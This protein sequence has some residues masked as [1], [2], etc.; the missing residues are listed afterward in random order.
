MN[1]NFP[2][3]PCR[4]PFF[5]AS[6]VDERLLFIVT[7][8]KNQMT[9]KV[10]ICFWALYFYSIGLCG[11][12]CINTLWKAYIEYLLDCCKQENLSCSCFD[13]TGDLSKDYHFAA[14]DIWRLFSM[15]HFIFLY[16]FFWGGG[17]WDWYSLL[18]FSICKDAKTLV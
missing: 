10:W 3:F 6:S 8:V 12:L 9:G 17:M 2:F 4:D 11:I 16:Y 7:F 14:N 13:S 5:P 18:F 1:F 15:K